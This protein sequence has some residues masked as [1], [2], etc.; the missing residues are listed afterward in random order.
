MREIDEHV[1]SIIQSLC[2]YC[3]GTAVARVLNKFTENNFEKLERLLEAHEEYSQAVR[4]ADSARLKGEVQK[5][6]RELEVDEDEQ[7]YLDRC[8]AGLFT[9]QQIDIV[10][11]RLANMGNRPIADEI[12]QLLDAKGTSV[13]E[14]REIIEEFLANLDASAREERH[15]LQGFVRVLVKRCGGVL[16]EEPEEP[17]KLEVQ[18]KE[19][20][21]P[22]PAEKEDPRKSESNPE[23]KEKKERK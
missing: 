3:T 5:I 1:V 11:V 21:A 9:L 19:L 14:I 16:P 7:L 4:E 13:Q 18:E 23:K 10:L 17:E 20:P 8:D 6:D 2:R 15:E 12:K 22:A